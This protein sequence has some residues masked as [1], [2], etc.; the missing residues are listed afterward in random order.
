MKIL[1]FFLCVICLFV[2]GCPD[3]QDYYVKADRA[4]FDVVAPRHEKY[5]NADE[6]LSP[7]DLELEINTLR[8][9]EKRLKTA[10]EE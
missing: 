6:D 8:S 2:A 9:W 5:L 4:T 7:E 1:L 3:V 10:E